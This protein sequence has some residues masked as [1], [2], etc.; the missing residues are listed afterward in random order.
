MVPIACLAQER[1]QNFCNLTK[2][3]TGVGFVQFDP[4][5][6][7]MNSIKWIFPLCKIGEI[8]KIQK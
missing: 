3:L 4:F 1:H 2:T 7:E 5:F 8:Q 6:L